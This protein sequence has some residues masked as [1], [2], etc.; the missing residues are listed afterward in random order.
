LEKQ[1]KIVKEGKA[2]DNEIRKQIHMSNKNSD[3]I[4]EINKRE[5]IIEIFDLLRPDG[6]QDGI[7]SATH[8][9]LHTLPTE[10][11]EV[12]SPLLC[13]M[14]ELD[15]TLNLEEFLDASMRLYNVRLI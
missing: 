13:E 8:I 11:L 5:R 6:D 3:R 12:L 10:I 4:I 14:E 7:I 9:D 15:T 1:Q 2:R